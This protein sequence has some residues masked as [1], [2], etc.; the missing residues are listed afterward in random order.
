MRR[1][2]MPIRCGDRGSV[3]FRNPVHVVA[4]SGASPSLE[5]VV[6]PLHP[7]IFSQI[8]PSAHV[9]HVCAPW[10]AL[11][12]TF[13]KIGQSRILRKIGRSKVGTYGAGWG[14]SRDRTSLAGLGHT[15]QHSTAIDGQCASM[16]W[17]SARSAVLG[18]MEG[19]QWPSALAHRYRSW[20]RRHSS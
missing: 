11:Q 10:R 13:L 2:D 4:A 12:R 9:T 8:R 3:H 20:R 5:L 15:V 1:L 18:G 7:R 19:V 16:A 14:G 6:R 17:A